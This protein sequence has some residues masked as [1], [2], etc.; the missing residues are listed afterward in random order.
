MIASAGILASLIVGAGMFSLP[1]VFVRAGLIYGVLALIFFTWVSGSLNSRYAGIIDKGGTDKRFAGYAK[2]HFGKKGYVS[3]LFFVLGGTA[4]TLTVY[5]AL[6]PSFF[7]LIFPFIPP[8]ASALIFWIA[9]T[10]IV[11]LGNK[12]GSAASLFVFAAMTAIIIFFGIFALFRGNAADMTPSTLFDWKNILLPFGPLLFSLSGRPA[13]SSIRERYKEKEYSLKKFRKAIKIGVIIPA[14]IYVVFVTMVIALSKE[15]VTPD[16]VTGLTALPSW[17]LVAMG[18]LG[19]LAILD[20]Y[21]LLGME[22]AGVLSRDVRMP[23]PISYILFAT[24][25]IAVY[26]LVSGNFLMLVGIAGGIF[27]AL[28]S[29]MVVLM[30]RKIFGNKPSDFPL[31]AAF[32]L[33]I[34]YEVIGLFR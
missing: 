2:E 11:F 32:V 26:F 34:I 31:I 30:G 18:I 28:E 20:S 17:G 12:K 1:H 24:I 6:A 9:G 14:V 10:M 29:I 25:P 33:G 21:A 4:I 5:L 13:L 22:F 7:S 3:A 23:K 15:G 27:L 19:I 8:T 16:A